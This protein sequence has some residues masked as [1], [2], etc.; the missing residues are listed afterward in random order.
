MSELGFTHVFEPGEDGWTLLLLHGTGGDE[1]DLVG[2]GRRLAPAAALLSPRGKVLEGDAPRFFRR[3]A[4]GQL[5]IPDLLE[6]TDVA[7]QRQ[8]ERDGVPVAR[9]LAVAGG[10]FSLSPCLRVSLSCVPLQTKRHRRRQVQQLADGRPGR[11]PRPGF[12]PVAEADEGQQAGG[13]H[14][15][16]RAGDRGGGQ[17]ELLGD[18]AG[19]EH[20]TA[21]AA[22]LAELG[23][24]PWSSGSAAKGQQRLGAYGARRNRAC[25][26]SE[27]PNITPSR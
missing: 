16:R 2:L 22:A 4:V 11:L 3:L 15:G 21:G 7:G 26:P 8:R 17:L 5:D 23:L 20:A 14:P 10:A 13:F 24:A 6:R 19:G 1:R 18:L 27:V 12:E 25:R 9:D